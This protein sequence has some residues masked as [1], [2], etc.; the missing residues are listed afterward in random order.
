M[1]PCFSLTR[2]REFT[3]EEIELDLN[4]VVIFLSHGFQNGLFA[5]GIPRFT[6]TDRILHEDG[7]DMSLGDDGLI[8]LQILDGATH[9]GECTQQGLV[10]PLGGLPMGHH[11]R[12]I[13][14]ERILDTRE[15][16]IVSGLASR[17]F[18]DAF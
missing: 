13:D 10:G 6:Q 12:W 11:T 7:T 8:V 3:L 14:L 16:I 18:Y 5:F 4:I 15:C 17:T 9:V 2:R 1:P